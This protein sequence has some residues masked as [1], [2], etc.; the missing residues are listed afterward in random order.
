MCIRDRDDPY[1][2][3]LIGKYLG[4]STVAFKTTNAGANVSA[5]NGGNN[6]SNS[7]VT[8]PNGE[9]I[10]F[11]ARPLLTPD[12]IMALL[13]GWQGKGWRWGILDMRGTRPFKVRLSAVSESATCTARL[14]TYRPPLS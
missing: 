1:T 8:L 10:Q 11:A 7:S 14:G 4:V 9:S 13:S 12:E 5:Q 6:G 2:S 3:E